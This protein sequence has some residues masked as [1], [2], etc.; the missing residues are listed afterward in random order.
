MFHKAV[1]VLLAHKDREGSGG[2]HMFC[3]WYMAL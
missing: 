3:I 1:V 2:V